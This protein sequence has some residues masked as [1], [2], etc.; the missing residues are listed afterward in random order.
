MENRSNH[1]PAQVRLKRERSETL[2]CSK[3]PLH[4]GPKEGHRLFIS[5]DVET[6]GDIKEATRLDK[7][8]ISFALR[9]Q[10]A[11]SLNPGPC[12]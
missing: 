2:R 8:G 3:A 12:D 7:V 10:A 4:M 9:V 11:P 1:R 5:E 6:S